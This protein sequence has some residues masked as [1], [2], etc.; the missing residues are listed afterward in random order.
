MGFKSSI[1]LGSIKLY[2]NNHENLSGNK[3]IKNR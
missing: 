1:K 2:D 3:K